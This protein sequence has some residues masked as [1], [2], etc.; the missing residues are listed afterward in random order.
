MPP[1]ED[2]MHPASSVGPASGIAPPESNPQPHSLIAD[3]MQLTNSPVWP[4][5]GIC[6]PKHDPV[7]PPSSAQAKALVIAPLHTQSAPHAAICL[8]H[9]FAMHGQHA[10]RSGDWGAG[11]VPP[12][13]SSPTPAPLSCSTSE[14]GLNVASDSPDGVPAST[15][16]VPDGTAASWWS[17]GTSCTLPP[18]ATISPSKANPARRAFPTP[19]SM[20]VLHAARLRGVRRPLDDSWPSRATAV[21]PSAARPPFRPPL[22]SLRG[23]GPGASPSLLPPDQARFRVARQRL[24]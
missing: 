20:A 21:D 2:W 18:Q 17:P 23:G 15:R 10:L 14:G 5:S 7:E 9:P 3:N 12:K 11:R 24:G 8:G 6:G 13:H 19:V 4:W 16:G 22:S 1:P